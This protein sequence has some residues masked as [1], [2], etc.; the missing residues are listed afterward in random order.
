MQ[1]LDQAARRLIAESLVS[2]IAEMRELDEWP[3]V[4]LPVGLILVD[5]LAAL[6]FTDAEAR[7]ILG[8]DVVTYV[9]APYGAA[10]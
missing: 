7:D 3:G 10:W 6:G 9:T 2:L 8:D 1:M 5:V 4:R